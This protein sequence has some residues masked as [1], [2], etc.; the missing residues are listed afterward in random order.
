MSG[1]FRVGVEDTIGQIVFDEFLFIRHIAEDTL[2]LIRGS[3]FPKVGLIL[4]PFTLVAFGAEDLEVFIDRFA[5]FGTWND[6][7]HMEHGIIPGSSA[8]GTTPFTVR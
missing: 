4:I 2:H 6:M 3:H 7:I 8:E 5:A 1:G